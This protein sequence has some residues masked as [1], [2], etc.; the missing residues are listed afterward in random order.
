M[1]SLRMNIIRQ[2]SR[3]WNTFKMRSSNM[4]TCQYIYCLSSEFRCLVTLL[5]NEPCS[6]RN[7]RQVTTDKRAAVHKFEKL[8]EVFPQAVFKGKLVI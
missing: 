2:F 7:R 4:S 5:T 8:L 1:G 3:P 6:H